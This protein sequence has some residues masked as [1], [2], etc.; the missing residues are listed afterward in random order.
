MNRGGDRS[1]KNGKNV[2]N[3]VLPVP[4]KK[5]LWKCIKNPADNRNILIGR[6]GTRGA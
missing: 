6:K 3:P 4:S 5:D 1:K 2:G